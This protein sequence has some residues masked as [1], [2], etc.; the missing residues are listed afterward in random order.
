MHA[1][2]SG[3]D[4]DRTKPRRPASRS[5]S[6]APQAAVRPE[7]VAVLPGAVSALQH[8]AGNA[9]AAHAVQRTQRHSGRGAGRGPSAPVQRAPLAEMLG[10]QEV[11]E[12]T[13]VAVDKGGVGLDEL[14]LRLNANGLRTAESLNIKLSSGSEKMGHH[15]HVFMWDSR[16]KGLEGRAKIV[17]AVG[18]D[19][20]IDVKIRMAGM[21]ESGPIIPGALKGDHPTKLGG[22][23]DNGAWAYKGDIPRKYLFIVGLDQPSHAGFQDWYEG[24]G[25]PDGHAA[26]FGP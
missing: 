15:Q 8:S 2:E 24:K 26:Q 21:N 1:K 19:S 22:A 10:R 9:A 7:A 20:S 13:H 23:S 5:L 6:G 12:Y 14:Y 25:W 17:E 18:Q 4:P 11:K 16:S 3:R